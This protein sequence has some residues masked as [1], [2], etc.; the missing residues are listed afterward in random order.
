MQFVADRAIIL[1]HVTPALIT[2]TRVSLITHFK[3]ASGFSLSLCPSLPLSLSLSLASLFYFP[4]PPFLVSRPR[5]GRIF[6]KVAFYRVSFK[7]FFSPLF[8]LSFFSLSTPITRCFCDAT[9]SL[10]SFYCVDQF[11]SHLSRYIIRKITFASLIS[12]STS[13]YNETFS[14]HLT[15]LLLSSFRG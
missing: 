9:C 14:R 4:E 11:D 3:A 7:L 6:K 8:L 12:L 13:L 10:I 1:A 2:R 15:A 5:K